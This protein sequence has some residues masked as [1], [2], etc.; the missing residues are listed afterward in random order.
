[1]WVRKK[2]SGEQQRQKT[3]PLSTL[4]PG[5]HA[6]TEGG[7]YIPTALIYIGLALLSLLLYFP[8]AWH[9]FI[10]LADYEYVRDNP[11]VATGL[12]WPNFLWA[13]RTGHTGLWQPLTWLSHMRDSEFSGMSPALPHLNN[14]LLHAANTLLLFFVLY[15][16][17]GVRW[18]SAFVAALFAV[19]PLNV[20]SVAW[21]A[22][23]KDLLG[24]FFFLLTLLAYGQ[25]LERRGTGPYLLMLF[26]FAL[27]LM[28]SPIIVTLPAV[29]F[30]ID[31][32]P[33]RY[34][35]VGV[36][37]KRI[38]YEKIPLFALSIV[39]C[40]ATF[41]IHK[42]AGGLSIFDTVP[43]VARL[44]NALLSYAHYLGK[45]FWPTNLAIPYRY[46][47]TFNPIVLCAVGV[48][49]VG[50][51]V[52][53]V[54][55]RKKTP[56]LFTGWF[57]YLGTLVPMIGLTQ[58]GAQSMA[59]RYAYIPAI[60]IMI[61]V[62]WTCADLFP[63]WQMSRRMIVSLGVAVI[64][65]CVAKTSFQLNYWENTE[66]L[67][68]HSIEVDPENYLALET[69]GNEYVREKH[70]DE[71]VTVFDDAL[72]VTR[73]R[74]FTRATQATILY[75]QGR[76]AEAAE[77]YEKALRFVVPWLNLLGSSD[78]TRV[79]LLMNNLAW[80][81]ATIP[82][83][84]SRNAEEALQL[85]KR[86][87]ELSDHAD[88]VQLNTLAAAQAETGQFSVASATARQALDLAQA[89]KQ[90]NLVGVIQRCI[91]FYEAHE[92]VRQFPNQMKAEKKAP[93]PEHSIDIDLSPILRRGPRSPAQ[94]PVPF[95]PLQLSDPARSPSSLPPLQ[96]PSP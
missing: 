26:V 96:T 61:G 4:F 25:Y 16:F 11:H 79:A 41:F 47:Q 85:A 12:T 29:L 93:F 71:A 87:L 77:Q 54:C 80:I 65:V 7:A 78:R 55:V 32:W 45:I 13:F 68:K 9:D 89:Q 10:A 27:G 70:F 31:Y 56:Y 39:S 43:R 37:L 5:V 64:F 53:V 58:I 23:R 38:V 34:L 52:I 15:W 8:S 95:L 83:A 86:S 40:I 92:S 19:H 75:S 57:W 42:K 50:I 36:G 82:D 81:R 2:H 94:S 18:R 62:V 51:S 74:P 6:W 24:T 76:A 48:L 90:I 14:T 28:T 84:G 59:D 91:D 73:E 46:D 17:S 22:E 21:I 35:E 69:L 1:M 72:R 67:L 63:R 20:E 33:L 3:K 49:L 60:G 88:A 44:E 30:L 66:T